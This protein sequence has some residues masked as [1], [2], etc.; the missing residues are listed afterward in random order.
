MN[1]YDV[2]GKIVESNPQA[3]KLLGYSNQELKGLSGE[4][5]AEVYF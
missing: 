3:S 1:I 2:E 4:L 5:V